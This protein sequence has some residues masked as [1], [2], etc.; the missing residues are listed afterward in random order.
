MDQTYDVDREFLRYVRRYL[1]EIFDEA[2][3]RRFADIEMIRGI[4]ASEP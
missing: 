1:A 3:R 4:R 2:E